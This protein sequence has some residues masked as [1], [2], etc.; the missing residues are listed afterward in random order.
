MSLPPARAAG[1]CRQPEAS[2]PA[3]LRTEP[4]ALRRTLILLVVLYL[5]LFLVV[6]LASVFT[7]ALRRGL[8]AYLQAV[9]EPVAL[10][11]IR[12]TLVVAAI[13]VPLNVFFGITASWAITKFDFPGKHALM[14]LIDLP[15]SVS[16]VVSGLIYVLL[17]GLQG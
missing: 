15:F 11:A 8:G 14:T 10:A 1:S 12:L 16:P 5:G 2:G 9:S 7:E 6:P 17:L 4:P 3:S 13:A